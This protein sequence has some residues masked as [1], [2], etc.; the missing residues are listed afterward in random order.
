MGGAPRMRTLAVI[1]ARLGASRLPRKPLRLLA[2][3]PLVV[4]VWQRVES[5]GL[6]DRCVIA[7]DSEEV[8]EAV[9]PHGAQVVLTSASHPSGTDRVAEVAARS[10]FGTFEAIINVQGDEPF[11]SRSALRGAVSQVTSGNFPLGTV[12]V[13]ANDAILDEPN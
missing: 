8:A 5:L 13:R 2:G 3:L 10:E 6:A 1:P 4:R 11:V 12:A 7:T 9:R